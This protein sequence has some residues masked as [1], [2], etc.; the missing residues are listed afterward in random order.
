MFEAIIYALTKHEQMAV[1]R[2]QNDVLCTPILLI[3]TNSDYYFFVR[4]GILPTV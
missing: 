3:F 4:N 1:K 2:K